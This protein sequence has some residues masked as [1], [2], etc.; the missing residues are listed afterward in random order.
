MPDTPQI[1]QGCDHE[2]TLSRCRASIKDSIK[3]WLLS[4][5]L[6]AARRASLTEPYAANS[7]ALNT[8]KKSLGE[9]AFWYFS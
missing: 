9:L 3:P 2:I 5:A 7:G 4:E 8:I 6:L 1:M